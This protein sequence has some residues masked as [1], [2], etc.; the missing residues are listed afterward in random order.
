MTEKI[1]LMVK[2]YSQLDQKRALFALVFDWTIIVLA[3]MFF[4]QINS[5]WLYPI[6]VIM[7]GARQ[8]ALGVISH[9]I[10][11]YRFLHNRK[12]ADWIGN[13][14]I[15]WPMF[16]TIN[17]YRSMHLRHHS[18]VNTMED[19]DLV[20][21]QGKWDWVFPKTKKQLYSLFLMDI[22]G[23]NTLQ[24]FKKLFFYQHDQK[25]KN[26]Y[27]KISIFHYW[28]QAIYYLIL[29]VV[30]FL[31]DNLTNYF[32]FW[33]IPML[34]WLKF[35]KRIRAM[36]EHFGIHNNHYDEITRTTLTNSFGKF[37]LCPHGINYHV[38]HHR[39]PGIPMYRLEDFHK[40]LKGTG[41]FG[42]MGHISNGYFLDVMKEMTIDCELNRMF[43]KLSSALKSSTH[44]RKVYK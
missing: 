36:A 38:E 39:Y 19:P 15:T 32:L 21:R 23:L 6:V 34:T 10:V 41:L 18:H 7:I 14:F 30:L 22:S 35:A 42:K 43:K 9:D 4:K 31:S 40:A 28:A 25:L 5:W 11:H 3:I 17:G 13:L 1:E 24:Y 16:F 27:K 29:F 12:L 20:R 8:H 33:V 2:R 44:Y 37:L 26:D